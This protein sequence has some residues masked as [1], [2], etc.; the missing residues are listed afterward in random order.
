[1]LSLADEVAKR[2]YVLIPKYRPDEQGSVI[3]EEIAVVADFCRER[4]THKLA[5]RDRGQTAPNTYSSRYGLEPFPWHTDFA[6]WLMPPRFLLLRC[7]VGFPDVLTRLVDAHLVSAAV[8]AGTL[9][10]ALVRPRRPRG[11][12]LP[13]LRILSRPNPNSVLIRWDEEYIR[14]ASEAGRKGIAEFARAVATQEVTDIRLSEPGDTLIIDNWRMLH[15]RSH[16]PLTSAGRIL[17]RS[18]LEALH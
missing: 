1:M 2:G 13:L 9:F 18:Y 16:V 6:H 14:P 4:P 11:G 5:V 17:E 3:V 8:G 7:L 10:R 12:V 15:G